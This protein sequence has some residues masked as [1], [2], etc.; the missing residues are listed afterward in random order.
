[1]KQCKI[2]ISMLL[3]SLLLIAAVGCT[4]DKAETSSQAQTTS[5]AASELSGEATGSE[6]ASSE[7]ETSG[8]PE[9]MTALL[10]T[11]ETTWNVADAFNEG[12]AEEPEMGEYVKIESFSVPLTFTFNENGTYTLGI[13][14]ETLQSSLETVR[15]ELREG[16]TKYFE[17]MLEAEDPGTTV[18]DYLASMEMT[19]DDL[20]DIAMLGFEFMGEMYDFTAEWKAEDG[21]LYLGNEG[22]EIDETEYITY[23]LT[24]SELTL[25]ELF[26]ENIF[27]TFSE[28]MFPMVL[29]KA[30]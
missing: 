6:E 29:T 18:E 12:M 23:E 3:I 28:D 14:Q 30:A 4:D 26:T 8:T 9:E 22:E 24:D 11:W 16:Y 1:M 25:K 17:H 15:E 27:S 2:I 19:M 20:L 13:D 5:D 7:P 21:K 10:G